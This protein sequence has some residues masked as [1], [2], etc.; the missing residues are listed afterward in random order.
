MQGWESERGGV[1]VNPPCNEWPEQGLT[2]SVLT[3]QTQQLTGQLPS[4]QE[5]SLESLGGKVAWTLFLEDGLRGRKKLGACV[6]DV[7]CSRDSV[8]SLGC[9]LP[10]DPQDQTSQ[11]RPPLPQ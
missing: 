9:R 5:P 8:A 10:P 7:H 11:T 4:I 2:S 6:T 3:V 1:F